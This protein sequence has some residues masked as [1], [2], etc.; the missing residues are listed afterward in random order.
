MSEF[1]MKLFIRDRPLVNRF[2]SRTLRL[3]KYEA[4][5]LL[6]CSMIPLLV[7][8]GVPGTGY[9]G[10]GISNCRNATVLPFSDPAFGSRP[11]NGL[12]TELLNSVLTAE[13]RTSEELRYGRGM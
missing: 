12:A 11:L 4:P 5:A 13:S 7:E 1:Q 9:W 8:L 10:N 2:C 6:Y 3:S